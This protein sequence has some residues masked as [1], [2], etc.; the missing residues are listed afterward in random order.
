MELENIYKYS[1]QKTTLKSI[2]H[3]KYFVELLQLAQC[4]VAV[5]ATINPINISTLVKHQGDG[6][7]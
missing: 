4:H 7:G 6:I 3:E 2:N 5:A 1:E